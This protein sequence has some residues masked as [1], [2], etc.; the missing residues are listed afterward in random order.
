MAAL[1]TKLDADMVIHAGRQDPVA[2]VQR[3]LRDAYG[4]LVIAVSRNAFGEAP[5]ML[6]K[7]GSMSLLGLPPG[8]LRCP[9]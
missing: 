8:G 2:E 5:G 3:A 1:A 6:H 7:R 9:S 4:V